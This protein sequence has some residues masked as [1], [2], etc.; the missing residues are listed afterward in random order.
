MSAADDALFQRFGKAFPAGTV[1]CREGEPGREMFVAFELMG[2][3][4]R[5]G[6]PG[7][8]LPASASAS[9]SAIIVA[10]P[11]S[12]LRSIIAVKKKSASGCASTSFARSAGVRGVAGAA[13][14]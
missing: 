7:R 8:T 2:M 5:G 1:L 9:C 11:P 4:N 13:R 14:R 12:M 10:D 6:V 3:S